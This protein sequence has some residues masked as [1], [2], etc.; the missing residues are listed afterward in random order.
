MERHQPPLNVRA[1]AHLLGRSEKHAD[2]ASV[3]RIEEQLFGRVGFGLMNKRNLMGWHTCFHKFRTDIV[4]NV[5]SFGIGR[6]KVAED[7]L[8][9]ALGLRRAPNLE[10]A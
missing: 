3:H 10:D 8:S 4:V 2:P 1:S 6:R 9:G 7:K 5:E